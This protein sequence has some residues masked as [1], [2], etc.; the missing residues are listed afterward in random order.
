MSEGAAAAGGP[1]AQ[2]TTFLL[3]LK[4][5][6]SM[7][8][9]RILMAVDKT[10]AAMASLAHL[11]ARGMGLVETATGG[12][13]AAV[14]ASLGGMVEAT[15]VVTASTASAT[16]SVAEFS[17]EIIEGAVA[18][19]TMT[20][21]KDELKSYFDTFTKGLADKSSGLADFLGAASTTDVVKFLEGLK[22][23]MGSIAFDTDF[24]N[25]LTTGVSDRGKEFVRGLASAVGKEG[26]SDSIGRA[27]ASKQ[28]AVM[29]MVTGEVLEGITK[30]ETAHRGMVE[31]FRDT[32]SKYVRF[33]GADLA[34]ILMRFLGLRTLLEPLAAIFQDLIQPILVPLVPLLVKL[35]FAL[36][37]I[38]DF[39]VEVVSGIANFILQTK[40]LIWGLRALFVLGVVLVGGYIA[41]VVWLKAIALSTKTVV[42]WK[43]AWLVL[44]S[45]E[46]L[47]LKLKTFWTNAL[48]L[49]MRALPILA[50]VSF[51]MLLTQELGP[52]GKALSG[53]TIAVWALNFAMRGNLLGLVVAVAAAFVVFWKV[54]KPLGLVLIG[55]TVLVWAFNA[56]L[57]ANPIGLFIGFVTLAVGAVWLLW[58]GLMA[59][60]HMFVGGSPGLIPA[61]ELLGKV[62]GVVF[63]FIS[64]AVG[65]TV[66]LIVDAV[67]AVGVAVGWLFDWVSGLFSGFWNVLATMFMPT[68]LI[69]KIFSPM[70]SG[71]L[72]WMPGWMKWFFGIEETE[73]QE[74]VKAS[75][76]ATNAVK[77]ETEVKSGQTVKAKT[78]VVDTSVEETGVRTRQTV[79]A[80]TVAVDSAAEGTQSVALTEPVEEVGLMSSLFGG[81]FG[82]SPLGLMMKALT[83]I[84]KP[85]PIPP[86]RE[87]AEE[88]AKPMKE[89]IGALGYTMVRLHEDSM[90]KLQDVV[91][92]DDKMGKAAAFLIG[93]VS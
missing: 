45:K 29:R 76:V 2:T 86:I 60:W 39:F 14:E 79:R 89:A 82:F 72:D 46:L 4:D 49:S 13:S 61:V 19:N 68:R 18:I 80:K 8:L 47:L 75:E 38:S 67:K 10:T 53:V 23:E 52:L 11:T 63:G 9:E 55:L 6:M 85:A 26:L 28:V 71:I 93:G 84:V 37:P 41:H 22:K 30:I 78:Q 31:S 44:S 27:F 83:G 25:A 69:G 87:S 40:P 32:F 3:E 17:S 42:F 16:L 12:A 43:K 73:E 59:L 24:M 92:I 15:E 88:L 77:E 35:A 21:H 36:R 66:G 62:V 64:G 33:T 34:N 58:K 91:D 5:A 51:I 70:L 1:T 54:S 48:A 90:A 20:K 65:G 74:G 7:R 56:A 57:V 81:F 50:I